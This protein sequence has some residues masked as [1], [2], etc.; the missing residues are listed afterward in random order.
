M[1]INRR[2]LILSIIPLLLIMAEAAGP[3][4]WKFASMADS[5]GDDNGVN[6]AALTAVINRVNSENVDFLLFQGDAVT[7]TTTDI[8][9]ASQMDNW[10]G[11]MSALNCP[12]RYTPGNHEIQTSTA[13]V[14][15]LRPRV[16][17]PLNGPVGDEEMAYSFN[18]QNAHF[19]A[20]NSD[21]WGLQ[22]QVQNSW[23][24]ADL[25]NCDAMHIFVMSH[26]PAYPAGPHIG[27]ALDMYPDKRD[28]FW[29]ILAVSGVK[30][31]F[32]G[33]EHLYQRSQHNG[34][35][36]IINGTCGAPISTGIADTTAEYQYV[37][38]TVDGAN[39]S[40]VCRSDSGALLDSWSYT[41]TPPTTQTCGAAKLAGD[42]ES[43]RLRDKVVTYAKDDAI[44]V[45]E[46]DRSSAFKVVGVTGISAG[47]RVNVAGTPHT[48][49]NGEREIV[50][51]AMKLSSGNPLP[52]PLGMTNRDLLGGPYGQLPGVAGTGG[53]NNLSM[54]VRIWGRV[55]KIGTGDNAGMFYVN[56]GSDLT[57]GTQ[58][59]GSPNVGVRVVW[60]GTA[61]MGEMRVVT[62]ISSLFMN[63]DSI[64]RRILCTDPFVL[65]TW[66]AYNDVVYSSNPVH[67]HTALM[68]R[69]TTCTIGSG[70]PGPTTGELIDFNTGIGTGVTAT[71]TQSG[72]VVWQP[73][74]SSPN[75]SGGADCSPG[76]DAYGAFNPTTASLAGVVY[77]GASGWYVDVT[78]TGLN[79]AKRYAFTTS[80]NRFNSTYNDRITKYTISGADSFTN[81]STSGVTVTGGGA[82]IAFCTGNNT[83]A[84]Y[85][86]RWTN[87]NPGADGTFKVRAESGTTSQV[88]AYAFSAFKLTQSP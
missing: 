1:T 19:V 7:G 75:Y 79:P 49:A 59:D 45:E 35:Y 44:Y 43:I 78:F 9:T 60:S 17:M 82:S 42:T 22:H 87:I 24:T 10:L 48:N 18:Y 55:T 57:D 67:N 88:K 69:V 54:L 64:C 53:C 13:Q 58:W 86:A 36:Q 2:L 50:G 37:V 63:G 38:Y 34:I 77:Y 71:L 68:P 72:G 26:D 66:N 41:V 52:E 40:A 23:L 8:T 62:G 6:T 14:N 4:A 70:N 27:S 51:S 21:H 73:D 33:H 61:S 46:D 47:D 28:D 76:T 30:T 12:W 83:A 11:I 15:V 31:Y 74:A 56:D 39:V 81:S 65:T 85:V 32:C 29:N 20:L 16:N 3:A 25:A 80:A 5:R 84:G